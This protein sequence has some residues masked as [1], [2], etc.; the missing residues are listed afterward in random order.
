MVTGS[1][2][3]V[4]IQFRS[5]GIPHPHPITIEGISIEP[6]I[7]FGTVGMIAGGFEG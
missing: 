5:V 1:V 7:Q 6:P 4:E 3:I 2:N